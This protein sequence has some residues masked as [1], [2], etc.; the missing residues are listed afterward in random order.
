MSRRIS[1]VFVSLF[2]AVLL[3]ACA[4]EATYVDKDYTLQTVETT[5]RNQIELN[6]YKIQN[7]A[8]ISLKDII[9]LNNLK[10]E[11]VSFY[12][13]DNL[14]ILC[15]NA[16]CTRMDVYTF[17]LD[18]GTLQWMGAIEDI[19]EHYG[20]GTR[21]GVAEMNPLVI[22]EEMTNT[23][24]VLKDK[25]VLQEYNLDIENNITSIVA[26][27][28]IY[29]TD[30]EINA[31]KRIDLLIGDE[32]IFFENIETYSCSIREIKSVSE[33]GKYLYAT[34]VNK[35]T[36]QDTTFV[37]NIGTGEITADVNGKFACWE[38]DYA[39]YSG[40]FENSVYSIH[41]RIEDNYY[42]V[43]VAKLYP[44]VAYEYC[45]SN[46][47]TVITVETDGKMYDFASVDLKNMTTEY[48]SVIDMNSYYMSAFSEECNYSYCILDEKY[49][50]NPKRN[51]VVFEIVSD[52]DRRN[53]FLWDIESGK[54]VMKAVN[55]DSYGITLEDHAVQVENYGKISETV[56]EIYEEYGVAIYVGE[57]IPHTF[58]D[59]QALPIDDV[60]TI[61]NAVKQIKKVLGYYPQGFFN[62]FKS[63]G[64]AEGINIY[65]VGDMTPLSDEYIANPSGFSTGMMD[66]EVIALNINALTYIESN[67]C[68]EIA[69]TIY[70]R[71]R[72][73]E[74]YSGNV[75]FDINE[76]AKLNP[77]GFEYYNSYNHNYE[78]DLKY[79]GKL[80]DENQNLKEVYFIDGYSKLMLEEDLARL[81][82]FS[83][84]NYDEPYLESPNIKNKM[85]YF[86]QVIRRVWNNKGWPEETIWERAMK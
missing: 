44:N 43:K 32:E 49:S 61:Q 64:Y 79:T 67:L 54:N 73:Q 1:A 27:G 62:E 9:K 40:Y 70:K 7:S 86:Y 66:Y 16:E 28:Y 63:C 55:T 18:Y 12:D 65:L 13:C 34:G 58:T 84:V 17:S 8:M 6:D 46:G 31:I 37:I 57:N 78:T 35:I 20:E 83:M 68:H 75:Y 51:M 69:H 42:N 26:D 48:A 11:S 30:S 22:Q 15:T 76:W 52:S 19:L 38:S 72:Y 56:Q 45:I 4:N 82:E 36:L 25:S 81:M 47:D 41:Q 80:Y 77:K 21:F 71:I 23:Y 5:Q 85:N 74:N 14:L 2:V 29:Y 59:Y 60:T 33:D 50:Y 53:I 10:I 3:S 24:W 39:I